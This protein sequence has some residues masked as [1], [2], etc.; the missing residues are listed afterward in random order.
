MPRD[1]VPRFWPGWLQ[2]PDRH[3]PSGPPASA[4][5]PTGDLLDRARRYL[6]AIP[7]PVIGAGSDTA[8]L[9]A[10]CRLVRGFALSAP[11]AL[12]SASARKERA[13]DATGG[14]L[15]RLGARGIL[16]IKDVT[17]I[18]AMNRDTRASLLAA[19]REIH[20]G[21]WERNV[22]TDGGRSLRPPSA[23]CSPRSTRVAPSP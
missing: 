20:D 14:L 4:P 8:T 18:L 15:R 22:G 19:F 12:L 17:S 1:Q 10:A 11:E 5:R 21:R 7:L 16:V 3:P 9:S 6:A 2:R 23:G 13:K